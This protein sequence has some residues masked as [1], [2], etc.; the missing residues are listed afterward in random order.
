MMT[1]ARYF[2]RRM[3]AGG[4][5]DRPGPGHALPGDKPNWPRDRA[6]DVMHLKL[7]F[8][9]DLENHAVSGTATHHVSPLNE[10]LSSFELDAVD[11][12]I[13]A[14]T[15]D[16]QPA[17]FDYDGRKVRVHFGGARPRGKEVRAGCSSVPG[18]ASGSTS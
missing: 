10:G 13:L 8:T 15:V 2:E 7:E 11:M 18:R 3:D 9:L 16:K 5:I 1:E 4:Q 6:A 14:A 17:T 12:E